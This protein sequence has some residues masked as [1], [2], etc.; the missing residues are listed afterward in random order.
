MKNIANTMNLKNFKKNCVFTFAALLVAYFFSISCNSETITG[1]SNV[2]FPDSLISFQNHIYPL[3][4]PT[5]SYQGCHSDETQAGGRRITDYFSYF[6][7]NN[8]GLV[9]PSKPDN[10]VL[11]QLLDG[12]LPHYPYVYWRVNEN[13]KNGVR[14]WIL[15]GAKNN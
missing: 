11:V 5:C 6:E 4:K 12:R 1:S 9:I 2:V 13:Q 7:T 14:Q 3:I 8:L 15:E 10:S